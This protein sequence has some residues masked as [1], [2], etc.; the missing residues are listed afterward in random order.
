MVDDDITNLIVGKNA[1]A[2]KYDIFTS[3][4]G[5]KLF[6]LLEKM[7]PDLILLDIEMPEM[8]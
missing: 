8:N 1:L 7:T 2:E 5:T 3:P 6:L 4:S